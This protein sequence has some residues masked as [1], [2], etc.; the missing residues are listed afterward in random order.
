[1]WGSWWRKK[2]E[3]S[4]VRSDLN[5]EVLHLHLGW[6]EVWE[7]HQFLG[8]YDSLDRMERFIGSRP[9]REFRVRFIQRPRGCLHPQLESIGSFLARSGAGGQVL[10]YGPLEDAP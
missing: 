1:M 7:R 4:F 9:G 8:L 10:Y 2:K 6:T 3:P 5:F